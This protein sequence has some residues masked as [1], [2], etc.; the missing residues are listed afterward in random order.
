[1]RKKHHQN[2]RSTYL[3]VLC[4]CLAAQPIDHLR[5][6]VQLEYRVIHRL[7]QLL[8]RL[9]SI[10]HPRALV[11]LPRPLTTF[12]LFQHILNRLINLRFPFLVRKTIRHY[13]DGVRFVVAKIRI[14]G[15][16]T[17][18]QNF[19]FRQRDGVGVGWSSRACCG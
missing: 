7:S 2:C 19:G 17:A 12:H 4:P 3:E 5:R 16:E 14:G 10:P 18:D 9:I 15:E 6:R 13:L 8:Q 1:M 11:N